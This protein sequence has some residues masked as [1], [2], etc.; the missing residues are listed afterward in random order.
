MTKKGRLLFSAKSREGD[1]HVIA[2]AQL[3]ALLHTTH[4]AYMYL[5]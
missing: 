4:P 2:S 3:A 1:V 5:L